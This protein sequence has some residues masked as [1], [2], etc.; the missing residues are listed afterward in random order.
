LNDWK[1]YWFCELPKKVLSLKYSNKIRMRKK[2]LFLI[3]QVLILFIFSLHSQEKKDV[4]LFILSGQSNA[5]GHGDG[6]LL[7]AEYKTSNSEVL[8]YLQ[9]IGSW[10]NMAAL[11]PVRTTLGMTAN[12]FGTE[13]S[14]A[15][16]MKK[17]FPDKIIAVTK[18][19]TSGGTSIVGWD[20]DN[21]RS[22]WITDLEEVDNVDVAPLKLYDKL[23]SETKKS[24][25]L[26][27][28]NALVS[29][30][31]VYGMLWLQCERDNS[32]LSLVNKYEQR[33]TNLINNIRTDF[34]E[35]EMIALCLDAHLSRNQAA[36]KTVL[37]RVENDM[38]KVKIVETTGLTYHSGT[39][40]FNTG[41]HIEYGKRMCNAFIAM[42][43]NS[44][45]EKSLQPGSERIYLSSI[46]GVAKSIVFNNL[47]QKSN[48]FL[49]SSNGGL[50]K[51][52]ASISEGRYIWDGKS[53][54]GQSVPA[55]IYL[56]RIVYE[57]ESE[58]IKFIF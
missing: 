9:S 43:P 47:P 19:A 3:L 12:S 28:S 33:L 27:K 53:A 31:K 10:R 48:I 17:N 51:S 15:F 30:I 6:A 38:L 32:T 26:L 23:I 45:N 16:E 52:S 29:D 21:L 22:D 7:P 24:I 39:V 5:I 57:G 46:P 49:Y 50:I 36:F 37:R 1:F 34:E 58:V 25:D 13:L 14:F 2:K 18:V 41:G 40:H 35:P 11:G 42:A 20:K 55:G 56:A 8:L 44:V 4:M 54:S